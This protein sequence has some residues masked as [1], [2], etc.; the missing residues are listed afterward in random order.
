M[1]ITFS[2]SALVK[3]MNGKLTDYS[4]LDLF[5]FSKQAI[6]GTQKF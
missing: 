4:E 1:E 2:Q 6:I 5:I 3:I